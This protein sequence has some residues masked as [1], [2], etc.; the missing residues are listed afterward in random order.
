[1]IGRAYKE[2]TRNDYNYGQQLQEDK[3]KEMC[4][5]NNLSK[6]EFELFKKMQAETIVEKK[7]VDQFKIRAESPRN[8]MNSS[9]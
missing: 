9:K 7:S 4:E 3:D 8:R 6:I 2:F 1:M 5:V